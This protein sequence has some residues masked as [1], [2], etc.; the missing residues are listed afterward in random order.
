MTKIWNASHAHVSL[1]V[2]IFEASIVTKHYIGVNRGLYNT[3]DT[4]EDKQFF[5]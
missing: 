2:S 4:A 3:K 1:K 5:Y